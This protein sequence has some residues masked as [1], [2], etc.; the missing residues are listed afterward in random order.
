MTELRRYA[1]IGFF[2]ISI[3]G[4]LSHFFYQWSGENPMIG[5]F[6]PVN[7]S[8]WE[9]MKLLFFPA[10]LYLIL[11]YKKNSRFPGLVPAAILGILIGTFFIPI[12][13]Y[14]YTG[15]LGYHLLF[16]DV[17]TFY[18]SVAAACYTTCRFARSKGIIHLK[19]FLIVMVIALGA[20]FVVFSL[21]AY[22]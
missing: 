16:L 9:H 7:E 6:A 11:T 17:I 12:I 1:V 22:G 15:L 14:T 13:F 19:P 2:F 3:L 4:T 21:V 10:V 8:T 5:L 18:L 20:G